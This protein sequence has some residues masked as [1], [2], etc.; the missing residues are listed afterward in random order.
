MKVSSVW[1]N[2]FEEFMIRDRRHGIVMNIGLVRLRN[3]N[4]FDS[5]EYR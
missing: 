3:V 4:T 1:V 2:R 5:G